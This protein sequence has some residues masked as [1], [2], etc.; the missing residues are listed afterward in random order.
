VTEP[1]QPA[2]TLPSIAPIEEQSAQLS[3]QTAPEKS[4]IYQK[5]GVVLGA[6]LV[7]IMAAL[8]Y[9]LLDTRRNSGLPTLPPEPINIPS[10]SPSIPTIAPLLSP[11][12][13]LP[14]FVLHTSSGEKLTSPSDLSVVPALPESIPW[15]EYVVG[16]EDELHLMNTSVTVSDMDE[17]TQ[18]MLP[19]SYWM[20]TM[21]AEANNEIQ[22]GDVQR[23]MEMMLETAGWGY[24]L[25][26]GD[27]QIMGLIADGPT[28]GSMGWVGTNGT[29]IRIV[30]WSQGVVIDP[31]TSN[32]MTQYTFFV[33][34]E[35]T[36]EEVLY[37]RASK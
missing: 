8:V 7:V 18:V 36:V 20:A 16:G 3:P 13:A 22:L 11:T 1:L 12:S 35:V 27:V 26:I 9:V 14:D 24:R 34:D 15:E 31:T 17:T 2:S 6:L 28:G 25:D 5:M 19:G 33:S 10:L 23:V 37:R 21:T 4:L 30:N 32:S 29:R